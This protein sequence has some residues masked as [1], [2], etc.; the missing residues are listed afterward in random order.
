MKHL[1]TF[2]LLVAIAGLCAPM[3]EAAEVLTN[4][5]VVSLVKAGLGEELII[6]KIATSTGQYDTTTNALIKLKGEGV[7][8]KII[9][10]MIGAA[11]GAGPTAA[12][13]APTGPVAIPP[14]A[15]SQAP[16]ATP[17]PAVA[18]PGVPGM[19]V[20]QGQS[21]FV[22]VNDRVL[23]VLP[24]VPEFAHSMAKHF[25]P[26]YFGPGDTWHFVRGQKAVVRLPKGKPSFYTKV[27]PSA[28]QLMRLTYD[29]PRNF[30]YVVSTGATYRGSVSFLTNRAPDDIFEL[31]P[32]GE[33]EAGEYAFVAG[34]TFYDFGVE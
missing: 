30:R 22:R 17:P 24:V 34:G 4:D 23:E 6:S 8:D 19:M 16:V 33:L 5:A 11:S 1:R 26:F 9:Q 28:F 3:P 14:G 7:S 10:A 12:P 18:L 15:P 29:A 13:T 27:N 2:L 25:I 32:H 21:L 20:V 31:V